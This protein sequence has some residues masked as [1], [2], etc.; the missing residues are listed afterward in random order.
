MDGH[1][2]VNAVKGKIDRVAEDK[3]G[4]KWR[5]FIFQRGLCFLRGNGLEEGKVN[6]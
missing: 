5:I 1:C 6:A 4:E 3:G 2:Y